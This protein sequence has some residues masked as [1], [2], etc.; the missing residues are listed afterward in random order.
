MFF[1]KKALSYLVLPPGVF[2]LS[3][4]VLS[5]L[6]R[7]RAVRLLS[8]LSALVLYSLSVEPFKDLL[9]YPLEK[10]LR[11]PPDVKGDVIVVLG[12]GVYNSGVLKGTSLKRLIEGYRQHL[13][14]GYPIVLSGGSVSKTVPEAEIMEDVL[15]SLGVSKDVIFKDTVSRDTKENALYVKRMCDLLGCERVV[16]VTSAFHMRRAVW[17]FEKAGLKV[18]P[19]PTDFRFEGRYDLYSLFP[20]YSVLHD[21]SVALREYLALIFYRLFY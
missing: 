6:G 17:V 12:G 19:Y 20:K 3:F 5:V 21:S 9:Y 7:R 11:P 2:V 1:L 16:L 18:V 13:R 10:D 14:T 4:L 15:V 8:L